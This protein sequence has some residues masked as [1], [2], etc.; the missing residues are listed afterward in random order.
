MSEPAELE[1]PDTTVPIDA[2]VAGAPHDATP[3]AKPAAKGPD[4]RTIVLIA[5]LQAAGLLGKLFPHADLTVA[6]EL[7]KDYWPTRAVEDE[8]RLIRLAEQEAAT[9]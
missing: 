2:S 3:G 5:L 8:L 7:V 9:L 4:A 1:V 6:D